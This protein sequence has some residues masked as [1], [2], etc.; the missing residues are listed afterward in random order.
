MDSAANFRSR[1]AQY[2]RLAEA[3]TDDETR[4]FRFQMAEYFEQA[5]A[6]EEGRPPPDAATALP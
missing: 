2:R 6:A 1:A 4:R 5:A 3:A